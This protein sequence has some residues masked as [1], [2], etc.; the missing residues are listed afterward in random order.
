VNTTDKDVPRSCGLTSGTELE[1]AARNSFIS[2]HLLTFLHV[3]ICIL[4]FFNKTI[5]ISSHKHDVSGNAQDVIL[6]SIWSIPIKCVALAVTAK[7]S[8]QETAQKNSTVAYKTGSKEEYNSPRLA[9][10]CISNI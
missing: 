10:D 4:E 2:L 7:L 5:S 1:N 3:V 9:T 8:S 6:T